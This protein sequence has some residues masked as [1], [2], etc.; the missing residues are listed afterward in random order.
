MNTASHAVTAQVADSLEAP[1]DF[2][3]IN[4]E[5]VERLALALRTA[6]EYS[7]FSF[8]GVSPGLDYQIGPREA[9]RCRYAITLSDGVSIGQVE[10]TRHQPFWESELRVLECFVADFCLDLHLLVPPHP[11]QAQSAVA[12]SKL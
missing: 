1:L 12:C 3:G 5:T 4:G 9:H 6:L 10:I 8:K 2:Q 7:S 11:R